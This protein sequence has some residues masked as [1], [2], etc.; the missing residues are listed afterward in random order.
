MLN[1]PTLERL[2]E[3]GLSG[4]ATVYDELKANATADDLGFDERLGLMLD[5]EVDVRETKRYQARRRRAKLRQLAT[6]E[7]ADFRAPRQLDRKLFLKLADCAWINAGQNLLV[8]GPTGIGK[9]WLACALG[10]QA[11]RQN[12]PVLYTRLPRLMQDLALARADG[13]YPKI[14][15]SLGRVKLLILDDWGLAPLD[16]DARR[17]L[18]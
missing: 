3:L 16:P 5:R 1:N 6:V 4:M 18:M 12:L 8:I 2:N 15:D 13:R 17:D 9:T 10:H 7:D 14:I 11:C